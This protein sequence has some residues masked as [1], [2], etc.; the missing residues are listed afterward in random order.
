MLWADNGLALIV[1]DDRCIRLCDAVSGATLDEIR[2]GWAINSIAFVEGSD[3][4]QRLAVTG[5]RL[6][7]ARRRD[8]QAIG[9]LPDDGRLLL[10]DLGRRLPA[11]APKKMRSAVSSAPF[12]RAS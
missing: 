10:L 12:G 4:R 5:S 9:N 2:P 1:A 3:Q 8:I 6:M 7:L 11:N